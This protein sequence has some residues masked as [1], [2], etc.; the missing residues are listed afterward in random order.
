M[1]FSIVVRILIEHNLP[2]DEPMSLGW[3]KFLKIFY[4]FKK[5]SMLPYGA[6]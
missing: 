6:G 5:K 2:L 1:Y 4:G 3:T